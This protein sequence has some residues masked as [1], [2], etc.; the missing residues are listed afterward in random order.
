M[1]EG[2][3]P[4]LPEMIWPAAERWT[5]SLPEDMYDPFVEGSGR[6]PDQW[7]VETAKIEDSC[8]IAAE[9]DEARKIKQ[10]QAICN[11][12]R[13]REQFATVPEEG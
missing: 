4:Y 9:G 2:E 13:K 12:I 7:N 8:S 6:E 10:W 11:E 3:G 5:D 1:S